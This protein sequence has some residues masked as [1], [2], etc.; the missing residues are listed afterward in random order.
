MAEYIHKTSDETDLFDF[1]NMA[2]LV[3]HFSGL[4]IWLSANKNE[5][6]WADPKFVRP[7]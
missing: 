7:E 6:I 5:I 4:I 1:D 2:D 3:N